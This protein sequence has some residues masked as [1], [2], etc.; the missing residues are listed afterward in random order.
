MAVRRRSACASPRSSTRRP[1]PSAGAPLAVTSGARDSARVAGVVLPG[2]DPGH[3]LHLLARRHAERRVPQPRGLR[4]PGARGALVPVLQQEPAQHRREPA[5]AG[6]ADRS[7]HA[8]RA[9][10]CGCATSD[11]RRRAR[12]SS[13]WRCASRRSP[14][15]RASRASSSCSP[16]T[17]TRCCRWRRSKTKPARAR[18]RRPSG[19]AAAD[20]VFTMKALQDLSER[21][22]RADSLERL[23][24]SILAGLEESF[25]FTHSMILLPADDEGVLVTIASRGYPEN[26]AGAEARFGE[27]HHRHG[28]RGAQADPHLGADA[29]RCSTPTRCTSARRSRDSARRSPD[30]AARACRIRTASSACRCSSAASWS[31]CCASRARCRT[32][33][34]RRTRRRSSC[35]AAT[36]RSPSRTCSCTSG[37]SAIARG[38]AAG[39][40]RRPNGAAG[41]RAAAAASPRGGVLQRA[42]SAS[43]STAST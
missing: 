39:C 41:G 26:G 8:A 30:P 3:A 25:G 33:S 37:R 18:R 1:G 31:A 2:P 13:A 15:T 9:G 36:W 34:T 35:S 42:T 10:G 27:G 29:R 20:A 5:R 6:A 22:H 28:R 7:R 16:P 21:I 38:S 19:R 32:A 11:R 12:S 14:R 40:A 17:S 24:D 43:W 4:R 23:L